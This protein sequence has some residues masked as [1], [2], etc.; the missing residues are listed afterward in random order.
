MSC[1]IKVPG[2]HT[3]K[4]NDAKRSFNKP[5]VPNKGGMTAMMNNTI[6]KKERERLKNQG[7][8]Y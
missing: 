5:K 3:Q 7:A 4:M 2:Q 1:L 8:C 6:D